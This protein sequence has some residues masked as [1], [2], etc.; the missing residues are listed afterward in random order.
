[1]R[2]SYPLL[3]AIL[4]AVLFFSLV[5][6]PAVDRHKE[7]LDEIEVKSSTLARYRSFL[8]KAPEMEEEIKNA[9]A[10]LKKIGMMLIDAKS[11]AIGFSKLNSYAQGMMQRSGVEVISLKPLGEKRS[12]QYAAVPIEIN[13]TA[14]VKQVRDFLQY[15]STGEYLIRIDSLD[16]TVINTSMPDKLRMKVEISGYRPL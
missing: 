16:V 8:E 6:L 10:E 1:M 12:K 9:D 4:A 13:A 7:I 15:L 3:L 2:R 11:D 14:N 5:M